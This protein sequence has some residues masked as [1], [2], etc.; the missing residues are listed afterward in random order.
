MRMHYQN[1]EIAK[2]AARKI[3]GLT[4][5]KLSECQSALASSSGYVDWHELEEV[6][7][8]A[9][10][11]NGLRPDYE[12]VA[13]LI[14]GLTGKLG[15]AAGDIQH[16]LSHTPIIPRDWTLLDRMHLRAAV[17]RQMDI[18]DPGRRQPGAMGRFKYDRRPLILQSFGELTFCVSD[19]SPSIAMADFE[20]V[21]PRTSVP[22]LI[23]SRL[24]LAYGQWT[25]ADGSKVL[26]SRDYIP[27]WRVRAGGSV[28]RVSPRLWIDYVEERWFWGDH[29][30]P[31]DK[32]LLQHNELAR[33]SSYGVR[34]VPKLVEI[35]PR[36]VL[37]SRN[38]RIRSVARD[39]FG[40]WVYGRIADERKPFLVD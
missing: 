27:L 9:S 21:S 22:L 36:L 24:Y 12:M 25:E 34:G 10:G 35:L 30:S 6:S 7:A 5:L 19:G 14:S 29:N 31:W 37:S 23:P 17:F 8:Q 26:F 4:E 40:P 38:E 1:V 2:S 11:V 13:T 20:Y 33:L 15:A 28:E 18:P 39:H 16:A 32:K 3:A